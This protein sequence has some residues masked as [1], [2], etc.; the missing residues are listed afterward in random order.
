MIFASLFPWYGFPGV[1]PY[2]D[3]TLTENISGKNPYNKPIRSGNWFNYHIYKNNPVPPSGP[4]TLPEKL[5]CICSGISKFDSDFYYHGYFYRFIVSERFVNFLKENKLAEG[6]YDLC[7]IEMLSKKLDPLSDKKHYLIRFFKFHD[8]LFN[9]QESESIKKK[10]S[11]SNEVYFPSPKLSGISET[12]P[13]FL[14][15]QGF[16]RSAFLC[17]REIKEKLDKEKFKGFV[18]VPVDEY[19]DVQQFRD[20]YPMATKELM[21]HEDSRWFS[22]DGYGL[23]EK[24]QIPV[25]E[26]TLGTPRNVQ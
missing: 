25:K 13:F 4:F 9:W 21:Q 26:F 20:N 1:K 14:L 15:L 22:K 11:V 16:L 12:P 23:A 17:T 19:V 24:A 5:F 2:F 10:G 7:E 8:Q 3:S 6:E 18:M